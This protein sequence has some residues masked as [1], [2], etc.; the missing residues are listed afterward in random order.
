MDCNDSYCRYNSDGTCSC[1]SKITLDEDHSCE[2]F[3]D[4]ED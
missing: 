4:A 1:K 3:E 2:Q